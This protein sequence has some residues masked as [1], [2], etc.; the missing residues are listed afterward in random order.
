MNNAILV[1]RQVKIGPDFSF[2]TSLDNVATERKAC[3]YYETNLQ[4]FEKDASFIKS[5]VIIVI[6]TNVLL[7]LYTLP[8]SKRDG[9]LKY[10]SSNRDR[11]FI[12][13]QVVCEYLKHRSG[14]IFS[15][16]E[17]L[18]G[19][20]NELESAINELTV[21]GRKLL[22]N[23]LESFKQRAVIKNEMSSVVEKIDAW[24]RSIDE[25]IG[26]ADMAKEEVLKELKC[27]VE[28]AKQAASSLTKDKV[29]ETVLC[30]KNL[31]PLSF[32]EKKFLRG[33]YDAL[34]NQF[35][36]ERD[37]LRYAF[38][39]CGDRKK[40]ESG[41]DPCGDFYIYH[42]ILALMKEMDCDA[43]FITNDVAKSDWVLPNRLPFMHY[44]FDEYAHTGHMIN[45]VG[46]EAIPMDITPII[47][48]KEDPHEGELEEK[49]T[50]DLLVDSE[51]STPAEVVDLKDLPLVRRGKVI[52]E[53]QFVSELEICIDWAMNYGGGYVK[54]EF[55]LR[56]IL[57][58][59]KHYDYDYSRDVLQKLIKKKI[60]KSEEQEH[61]G[62]KFKCLVWGNKH[63]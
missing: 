48:E 29:L 50:S 32:E 43:M 55:F 46:L 2:W 38:P 51:K 7:Y 25:S 37:K 31:E 18:K 39:G 45:I 22:F 33:V 6:D 41:F 19:L 62:E 5:D 58:S 10:F 44:L 24:W 16:Q 54:E 14:Y 59:R 61:E 53:E 52:T 26:K 13:G 3:E 27:K 8:V 63:S 4:R 34:L 1:R 21:S 56:N 60:V 9:I 36:E 20:V 57:A 40:I 47:P 28:E 42:E 17:S 35:K 15:A 11:V 49:V 23:K 30:T 12:P